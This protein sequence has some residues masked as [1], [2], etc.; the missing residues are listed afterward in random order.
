MAK[1]GINTGSAPN[2]GDGDT[3]LVGAIKIN[4]NFDELYRF[5]GNGTNLNVGIWNKNSVG[6]NT[7]LSVGIGTTNASS[8]L[9][10]SGDGSFTGV[11]TSITFNGQVNSGFGTI[12]NIINTNSSI[13][14]LTGTSATITTYFGTDLTVTT[15]T[16]TNNNVTNLVSTAGTVTKFTSTSGT[17]TNL[18]GTAATITS[19]NSTN[20]NIVNC[21]LSNLTVTGSA[22]TITN[23]NIANIIGTA[24]TVTTLNVGSGVVT[25]LTSTNASIS[26][27]SGSNLDYSG[28]STLTTI[29]NANIVS[30]GI[31][32]STQ[33]SVGP[34]GSAININQNTISGP[35]EIVI[36]PSGVGDNTGS[37]RV[38]GDL[39]VDGSQFS[40]S[41]GDINIGDFTVGIA[42]NVETD[43][44]LDG[45]G[46]GIGSTNIKKTF[47]WDYGS[48]SLKSSESLN[49][50]ANKS[51]KIG[52]VEVLTSNQ[53]T[54]SNINSSGISTLSTSN[55]TNAVIS[56]GI[57]TNFTGVA[58]TVTNLLSQQLNVSGV[59]TLSNVNTVSGSTFFANQLS[60]AGVST[61]NQPVY[62]NNDVNFSD[63]AFFIDDKELNLGNS[64]SFKVYHAS[65]EWVGGRSSHVRDISGNFPMIVGGKQV[66]ITDETGL[67]NYSIFNSAGVEIYQNLNVSG[68]VTS[69]STFN[70]GTGGTVITTTSNG[71]VGINS[72]SPSKTLDIIGDVKVGVNTSQGII[73]TSPNGTQYRLIVDDAGILSTV[74]V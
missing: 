29:S 34:E 20:T 57:I 55:I 25:S 73:L 67:I 69:T 52:D 45:A 19:L 11:V 71:L 22:A 33:F 51:Y 35:S 59:S 63:H 21:T 5:L 28:I 53:L 9:T 70:V 24:V 6:I 37:L 32:T 46:I 4:S 42:T 43:L 3:L 30:S 10:V 1:L 23:G 8:A 2:V 64:N 13:T 18:T 41:T 15:S 36:D 44:L 39:Y 66:R 74:A 31:I 12:T 26:N 14:N 60:V 7:A 56:S 38:K 62:L 27:L 58:C 17:I 50:P 47:L 49:I 65:S 61:F 54:V 48:N 40:V 16:S 72:T 68:I